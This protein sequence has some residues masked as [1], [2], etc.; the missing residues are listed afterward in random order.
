ME[1]G[2]KVRIKIDELP[3]RAQR[4]TDVEL[5]MVFGGCAPVG[6]N[7]INNSDCCKGDCIQQGEGFQILFMHVRAMECGPGD[8][9]ST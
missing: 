6:M 5:Q 2:T 4:L 9:S 7:C 3:P 8:R 1:K